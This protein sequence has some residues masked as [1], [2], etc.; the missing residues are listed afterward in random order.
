M[1]RKRLLIAVPLAFVALLAVFALVGALAGV[2][3]E[4]DTAGSSAA[5]A[6]SEQL[7]REAATA[8]GAT[9]SGA[10]DD[11][12]AGNGD[13][14]YAAALPP[15]SSAPH[16]LLRTGDLQLLVARHG[17]QQAMQRISSLTTSMGGYIL[18]SYAGTGTPPWIYYPEPLTGVDDTVKGAA[19]EPALQGDTAV[20]S[21]GTTYAP[22]VQ[23]ASAD[24]SVVDGGD[25]P[26]GQIAVRVPGERFDAALARFS[27]LGRVE[28]A[29]TSSTDVSDQ[30]VDLKARLR[31]ARSVER[32]LLGFLEQAQTVQ[33]ALAVQDRLDQN[34][35]LIEQLKGQLTQ[36]SETTTYG[37]ITVSLRER[38]VPQPGAI[39]RSDTFSGAFTH[40]LH[41]IA[42]GAR[43][44]A[45]A[46]G[47]ILPFAA[48]FGGLATLAWYVRRRIA[49]R[50]PQHPQVIES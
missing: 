24:G 3:H 32:R 2:R 12:A 38:G 19:E 17:L 4:Q 27:A 37:T 22:D 10:T 1:T 20:S 48:L 45:V 29:S 31:H 23:D 7:Q 43:V 30:M 15:T 5:G 25:V 28:Q 40:S 36:L 44:S 47:A 39:D 33:A 9:K 41:L 49:G 18:S 26:Y 42:D 8:P 16:Y 35:L 50:R 6:N 13:T 11:A 14:T 21:D 34:Q 46:L